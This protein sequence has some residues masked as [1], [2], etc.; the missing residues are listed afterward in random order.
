MHPLQGQQLRLEL[1][2]QG[3][4]AHTRAT[5]VWLLLPLAV[6]AG[7]AADWS[8][9]SASAVRFKDEAAATGVSTFQAVSLERGQPVP[10]QARDGHPV[11][12]PGRWPLARP[13][14]QSTP[15]AHCGHS[16]SGAG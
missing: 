11:C 16:G 7:I 15:A 4:C 2:A 13:A 10:A 14:G 1:E 3:R 6:L 9:P 5:K 12:T 8:V